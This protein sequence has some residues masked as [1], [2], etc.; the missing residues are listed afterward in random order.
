MKVIIVSGTPGTGKTKLA[1]KLA[2]EKNA[3]HI[4]V[5]QIIKENKLHESYDRKRKCYIVDHKKL[6]KALIKLIKD[7]KKD[8]V[9]DSHLSHYLPSKYVD[10]CIITKTDLKVLKERLKARKYSQEKI[11]ENLEAEALDTCLVEA[12]ENKHKVK[13]VDTTK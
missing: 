4:D 9:I 5:N 8:L 11:K 6:N 10:L 1:K 2:K 12:L 3:E 7:S 13:V